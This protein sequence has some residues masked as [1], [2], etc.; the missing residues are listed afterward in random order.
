MKRVQ[1]TIDGELIGECDA[2]I[3]DLVKFYLTEGRKE[4]DI[5]D[6]LK[7]AGVAHAVSVVVNA[8]RAL[9]VKVGN[10]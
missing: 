8:K 6:E 2:D 9:G 3:F 10:L 4:K 7:V 1:L 5:A